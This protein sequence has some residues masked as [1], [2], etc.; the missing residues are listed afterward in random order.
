[1]KIGGH[2]DPETDIA[3]LRLEDYDPSTVIAE[4]VEAGLRELEP[5]TG[6]VTRLE[7][8]L[9]RN[10]S[11]LTIVADG[12]FPSVAKPLTGV[13]PGIYELAL[14][15]RTDAYRTIYAIQF[16]D[17]VWVVHAFQKKS[18]SGSATPR[19]EIELVFD[20][21]KRLKELLK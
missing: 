7:E 19:Q 4:E 9:N 3:W 13:G 17:A 1:M 16:E 5:A 8:S 6:Q 2:Y 10:L 12:G 11:A 18:K 14:L 20:R 21:V 15:Y